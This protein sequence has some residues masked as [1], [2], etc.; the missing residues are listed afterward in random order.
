MEQPAP[1]A[2]FIMDSVCLKLLHR[3]TASTYHALKNLHFIVKIPRGRPCRK[4][5]FP[6][7]V[8]TLFVAWNGVA[9]NSRY[10]RGLT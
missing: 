8:L 7:A 2:E 6:L 10:R 1:Q 4:P 3:F 9:S 5:F